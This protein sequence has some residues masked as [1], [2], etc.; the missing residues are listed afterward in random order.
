MR[1]GFFILLVLHFSVFSAFSIPLEDIISDDHV[2]QLYALERGRIM[3]I[4]FKNPAPLLLPDA[5]G[6]RQAVTA[7]QGKLNPNIMVETLYLYLKPEKLRSDAAAWDEE[8]KLNV[9]NHLISISSLTGIEYYS[10]SRGS[11]RTFYE[12]SGI[13]DSPQT[14]KPLADPVFTQIPAPLTLYARQKDLTFGDNIYKYDVTYSRDVIFFIQ[15]NVTALS[16]G[17]IPLIRSGNLHSVLAVIDCGNSILIYAISMV[18]TLSVSGFHDRIGNSFS[19][20]AEAVINW[21]NNKLQNGL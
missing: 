12:F 19:N 3:E 10:S 2:K 4:Q 6:L 5:G 17:I 13:I 9:F 18:K 16:Y 15:E 1:K 21:F 8:Q 14:K 20:R 7:A 11:M